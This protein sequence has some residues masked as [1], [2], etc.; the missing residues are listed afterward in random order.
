MYSKEQQIAFFK[1]TKDLIIEN[2][3]PELDSKNEIENLKQVLNFHEW[4]YYIQNDPVISDFEYD[5]LFKK[6]VKLE[7]QFPQYVTASSPTQR[8][9]NDIT[10]NLPTVQHLNQMLSLENSYNELDLIDFDK[11]IRKLTGAIGE[12]EYCVE[13]KFD[14]GSIA[15]VYENNNLMRG[16]T[17]GNGVQ[18]EDM[19]ANAKVIR[20]IPLKAE[21]LKLGMAKV[22][23]RGEALIRKDNFEKINRKREEDGLALFANPR[24]AAT[25]G[26]RTKDPNETSARGIEAFIYQLGYA[27]DK[28]GKDL[29]SNFK[30]HD[31]SIAL[32]GQLG[33][34]IPDKAH[35]VCKNIEEV[36]LFCEEWQ[37]KRDSYD[38]EIDGMV[39]K[40]N[41]LEFQKQCGFT[42]HHPRWAIAF[43]FKAKQATT[44]LIN[45][46]YQVG[47]VGSIT[48][49][50]KLDPVQ[51]AGVTVSSVSL[52][53][54]DFIV[55]K[56]I[57][58][59]DTVLVERAGDVI[60]YIVKPMEELRNGSEQIIQFPKYCP[61]NSN[62]NVPLTREEGESAW[63]CPDCSCGMQNVQKMIFHT[64]KDAMDIEGLG[65]SIVE[66]FAHEGI[67]KDLPD[68]YSL[69]YERIA[70]LDGFGVKS[71]Q[72]L[73]KSIEIAKQNPIS[74]L[75]H[76]L[77]IHHLGKKASK[78]IAGKLNH[79]MDLKNWVL[80]D[81]IAIKDVGP[82]VAENIIDYFSKAK[83]IALIEKMESYGVNMIQTDEDKEPESA[84]E[85]PLLGKTILFTGALQKFTREEAEKKAAQ[86]GA[87]VMSGVSSK[88]NILVVGEKAGSKLKKAKDLGSVE[89]L[90]EDE[91]EKIVLQN[92]Q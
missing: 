11:Q 75:L 44:K 36:V 6:L 64:S 86:A 61:I 12:I 43:K 68:I 56:D 74:R 83:N 63:R 2:S 13:P 37:E 3:I 70:E 51:L 88:L 85:G 25:G 34:K 1:T 15:L 48:P 55:G 41:S 77:S 29:L 16:A 20:T 38:Y 87:S 5:I 91:F 4:K 45:V 18:G 80:E 50:A 78:L 59:G 33:F 47:K 66:R 39:V 19:S 27:V 31:E 40:V 72:N 81:Y 73:Q 90:T 35:K 53:N 10:E 9:S 24:N 17:R 32:L 26:L 60:P 84:S 79:V 52:H 54:E 28:D 62:E 65:K 30:T 67:I 92:Q 7:E 82:V 8:V 76:S 71:I 46:E 49:V 89:I 42:S 69:D 57:R 14:G 22:E 23:L 21:F 58:I